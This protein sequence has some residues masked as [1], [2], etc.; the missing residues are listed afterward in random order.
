MAA[1]LSVQDG[2]QI[3]KARSGG[4]GSPFASPEEVVRRASIGRKA[5]DAL[6]Q[7]DAFGSMGSSRQEALWAAKG[8]EHDIP[9]LLRLA[10]AQAAVGEP[11]LLKEPARDLPPEIS[12]QAVVLEC[13]ANGL[14]LAKHPLALLRPQQRALGCID[15][16][17]LARLMPGKRIKLAGWC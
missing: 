5:M 2:Q 1:G 17:E 14:T 16:R 3:V 11:P 9:P 10:A 12:G 15:T 4:N 7:A 8:V 6:A 13:M